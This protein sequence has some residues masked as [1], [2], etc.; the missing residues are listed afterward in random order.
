MR[1]CVC[2]SMHACVCVHARARVFVCGQHYHNE[3]TSTRVEVS[4]PGWPSSGYSEAVVLSGL[5]KSLHSGIASR[6]HTPPPLEDKETLSLSRSRFKRDCDF[7]NECIGM[8]QSLLLETIREAL[9]ET[10]RNMGDF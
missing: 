3:T 5:E 6:D 2:L 8:L 4:D 7:V 9:K 10:R 1:A